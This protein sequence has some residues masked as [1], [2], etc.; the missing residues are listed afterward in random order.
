MVKCEIYLLFCENPDIVFTSDGVLY[1]PDIARVVL[2]ID[3]SFAAARGFLAGIAQYCSLFGPW[4]IYREP[5]APYK[6]FTGRQSTLS[7]IKHY[8]PDGI[9]LMADTHNPKEIIRLGKPMIIPAE[10]SRLDSNIPTIHS[11]CPATGKMAAEHLLERGFKHFAYCGFPRV[12]WSR[13]RQT[14]FCRHLAQAG[15]DTHIYQPPGTQKDRYWETEQPDLIRWLTSLP[16][17]V[18]LMACNDDRGHHVIEACTVAGLHVPE[19]VAVIGSD[20]DELVC[21][22]CHPALSSVVRYVQ[23]A[24]FEAARL[25]DQLM[26]GEKMAGQKIF[27]Y[28][29][30]VVTRQSTDILA[31]EDRDL[32]RAVHFIRKHAKNGIRVDDV[33]EAGFL[34]RRVLEMRFRKMLHRSIHDE[35]TRARMNDACRLLTE[36]LLPACRIAS[37]LG[38]PGISE[39]THAF[40][41]IMKLSPA[42]YRKKH[43]VK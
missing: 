37:T 31:M 40:H 30:H 27:D 38:Y 8:Q 32:A 39:F 9:I 13:E 21:G 23:R 43:G 20:N 41:K 42:G 35:I 7:R 2:L 1:M 36:T 28:P 22:L 25:L 15:Y 5:I 11:D 3:V 34:S 14:G 17:P 4:R 10:L 26:A 12:Y 33:V 19:D 6:S 16:K 24:G 18:G 29:T